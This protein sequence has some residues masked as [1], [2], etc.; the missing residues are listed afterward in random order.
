M[1]IYELFVGCLLWLLFIDLFCDLFNLCY[2]R[3]QIVVGIN[4]A[5][6]ITYLLI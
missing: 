5:N 6:G 2:I 1:F 4:L 3:F